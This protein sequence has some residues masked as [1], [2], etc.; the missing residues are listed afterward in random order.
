MLETLPIE[1]SRK[2][3]IDP[4]GCWLWQ[5]AISTGYGHMRNRNGSNLVHRIVYELLVGPIPS[6]L[7]ID[8]LCRVRRCCN[9]KHLEPVTR[10]I[11]CQRGITPRIGNYYRGPRPERQRA[12]CEKG[13]PLSDDNLYI[14]PKGARGCMACRREVMRRRRERHPDE[15]RKWESSRL[16]S[17]QRALRKIEA[18]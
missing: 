15:W 11:N 13:H 2:I 9:P 3:L 12:F 14:S 1:I 7:E 17:T 8:H 5:G 6:H 16:W 10:S 4:S 18:A